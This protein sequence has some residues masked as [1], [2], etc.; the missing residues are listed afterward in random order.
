MAAQSG[1]GR[2]RRQD[3]PGARDQA[4][5]KR[6]DTRGARTA[7]VSGW[8]G[9]DTARKFRAFT[10]HEGVD[11]GAALEDAM[12]DYL[13]KVG[14]Y[15]AQRRHTTAPPDLSPPEPAAPN[16]HLPAA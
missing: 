4:R 10:A 8:V 3:V 16:L 7:R 12:Q 5:S 9:P 13:S 1:G 15:V 14:F 6:Q 2:P 11:T